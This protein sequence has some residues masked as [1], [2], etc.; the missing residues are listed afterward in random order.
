MEPPNCRQRLWE[1][2]V[3]EGT[4]ETV[5]PAMP[6]C[7]H[8]L[9]RLLLPARLTANTAGTGLRTDAVQHRSPLGGQ[10]QG[11]AGR[12]AGAG[13]H[14]VQISKVR[15]E[16]KFRRSAKVNRYHR[17]R[18]GRFRCWRQMPRISATESPVRSPAVF[19]AKLPPTRFQS[20][21]GRP[22]R[23]TATVKFDDSARPRD[24]TANG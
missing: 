17:R 20:P 12:K 24:R 1:G 22:T 16:L 5:I 4:A 11:C 14:I 6:L 2:R 3:T 7:R 18:G 19:R 13:H 10:D 21:P 9:L 8:P 23:R 15:L